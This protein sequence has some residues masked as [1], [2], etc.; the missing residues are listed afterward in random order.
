MK[1]EREKCAKEKKIYEE[2]FEATS[3]IEKSTETEE[4]P[5]LDGKRKLEEDKKHYKKRKVLHQ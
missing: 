1:N 5:L 2:N 4:I 3:K